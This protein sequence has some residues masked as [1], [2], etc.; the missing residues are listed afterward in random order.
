MMLLE[1]IRLA[2]ERTDDTLSAILNELGLPPATYFRWLERQA[3]DR[4]VDLTPPGRE[5]ILPTPAEVVAVRAFSLKY[6]IMGYKR[7]AWLMV[8]KDVAALSPYR[9]AAILREAGLLRTQTLPPTASLSRP[10]AAERPDEQWHIDIMYLLIASTWYYLVDII[11]AFSRYL[12][13]W[14]LN[15]TMQADTVTL[16]VQEALDRLSSRRPGESKIVHDHGS[17]FMSGEWRSVVAGNDVTDILT[18]VAHPQSNG[19][20][21]R[22]H[23][24]HREEIF[25]TPPDD[26]YN[27]LEIME[28]CSAFYNLERPHSALKYL[29][30]IDYYRGDPEV[31]LTERQKKLERAAE[32]RRL[33]WKQNGS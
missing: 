22:L 8:D 24:T 6:A 4:L 9:V 5:L 30:P 20:V 19:V 31:R 13:H 25:D 21:E 12:V 1:T 2:Q 3:T 16:T 28:A 15:R 27:A 33:F 17:Q 14:S 7:L 11:D 10:P 18:R 26:Y 32:E 23:R 29:C